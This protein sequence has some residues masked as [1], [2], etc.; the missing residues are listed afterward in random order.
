M[1]P[2]KPVNRRLSNL[3]QG[4]SVHIR[5]GD[6][7]SGR[8]KVVGSSTQPCSYN[9]LTEQGNT[10]RRNRRHIIKTGEKL[11]GM[12]SDSECSLVDEPIAERIPRPQQFPGGHP[13]NA[14]N[15]EPAL[16]DNE[17]ADHVAT[18]TRSGR[19]VRQPAGYEEYVML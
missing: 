1:Y 7:W 19:H 9:I 8:G 16:N 11:F 12:D 5:K 14:I 6:T 13:A 17:V 10:L 4:D 18:Q 3:K 15:E 2:H